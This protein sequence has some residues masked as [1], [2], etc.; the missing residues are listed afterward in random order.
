VPSSAELEESMMKSIKPFKAQPLSRDVLES[1]GDLGV[2]R[3]PARDVTV[4]VEFKFETDKR[5]ELRPTPAAE[6]YI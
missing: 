1:K 4:P 2:P 3:V 6:F 5:L